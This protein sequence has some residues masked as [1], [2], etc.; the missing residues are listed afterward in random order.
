MILSIILFRIY[1]YSWQGGCDKKKS[2]EVKTKISLPDNI[3]ETPENIKHFTNKD[4]LILS[5]EA[6]GACALNAGSAH[7]F[8]DQSQGR[9][10]RSVVN[11]HI[12]DRWSFYSAKVSFPY[13]RQVG[14]KG[15]WVKF[16]QPDQYLEFLRS[17][18][19]EILWSDSEEL[20]AIANLY[21]IDIRIITTNGAEDPNPTMNTVG[22][23]E[24][25]KKFSSWKSSKHDCSSHK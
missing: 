2:K 10:F 13:E 8:E 23:V 12:A 9:R 21:Q 18:N 4:D 11:N 17:K 22:P 1:F 3:K 14:V 20:L 16:D 6:D 15:K 25:L 5:I 19:S 7:I 24:E